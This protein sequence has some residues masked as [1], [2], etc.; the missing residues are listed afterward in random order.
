MFPEA[1]KGLAGTWSFS[2]L[3]HGLGDLSKIEQ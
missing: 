1:E 3:L 2:S